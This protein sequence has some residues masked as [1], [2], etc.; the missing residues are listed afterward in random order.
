MS[1]TSFVAHQTKVDST[2][3]CY[4][5]TPSISLAIQS[6]QNC[7]VSIFSAVRHVN[8]QQ[9]QIFERYSSHHLS[10]LNNLSSPPL[11]FFQSNLPPSFPLQPPLQPPSP[12]PHFFH[13]LSSKYIRYRKH[14]QTI[15]YKD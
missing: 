12:P 15:T 11:G 7:L 14:V 10:L 1:F 2:A 4:F 9:N 13:L 6:G 8:G 5:L 3:H